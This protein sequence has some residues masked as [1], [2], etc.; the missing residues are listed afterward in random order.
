[1]LN[2]TFQDIDLGGMDFA[3]GAW[4]E[5][6]DCAQDHDWGWIEATIRQKIKQHH[7]S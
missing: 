1:L 4:E 5:L 2:A 3:A 6:L 7:G